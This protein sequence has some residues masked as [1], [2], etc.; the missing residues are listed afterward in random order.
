MAEQFA[1]CYAEERRET[2]RHHM[3]ME[4]Y[5]APAVKPLTSS[6]APSD[7][8]PL[9]IRAGGPVSG[10]ILGGCLWGPRECGKP[11]RDGARLIQQ[12]GLYLWIAGGKA[13]SMANVAHRSPRHGRIN[14]VYTPRAERKKARRAL[15]AD[16]GLRCRR[17]V[18]Y[19]CCMPIRPTRSPIDCINIS[20][21]ARDD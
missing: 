14:A 10:R 3:T 12:G 9:K 17:T 15:V 13:V 6:R 5:H 8:P 7:R 1:S 19:P 4:S 20:G 11:G 21:L 16:L 18:W 2:Y